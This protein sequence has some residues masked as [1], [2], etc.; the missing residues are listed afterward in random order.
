[1]HFT[2]F[3]WMPQQP[4]SHP[5]HLQTFFP[6]RES[7]KTWT[8]G[9]VLLLAV[10]GNVGDKVPIEV[11]LLL[12]LSLGVW[13]RTSQYSITHFPFLGCFLCLIAPHRKAKGFS[14]YFVINGSWKLIWLFYL[15]VHVS[16][17]TQHA[18]ALQTLWVRVL[19]VCYP[20]FIFC[21][22]HCRITLSETLSVLICI[23]IK[24]SQC[25]ISLWNQNTNSCW[26]QWRQFQWLQWSC[27]H[28]W[29]LKINLAH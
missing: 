3:A 24:C 19:L 20:A 18:R 10:S 29:E 22:Y 4:R 6:S 27:V 21:C 23:E 2:V 16:N 13:D 25:K 14:S 28:L 7:I 1:M 26:L 15:A 11:V 12:G 8:L 5:F 17:Y 9:R